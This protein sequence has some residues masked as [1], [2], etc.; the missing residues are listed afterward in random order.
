[1]DDPQ[2][3]LTLHWDAPQPIRTVELSF[4]TDF[5]HPMESV[6]LT[7]PERAMPFCVKA[8][9]ICIDGREAAHITGNHQTRRQLVLD[10]PVWARSVTIEIL[11]RWDTSPAALFEV[12]C[13]E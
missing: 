5:D 4:D 7:Q 6:L 2:P 10:R 3:A 1:L 8:L 11:E 13:Y 12:R 9:R